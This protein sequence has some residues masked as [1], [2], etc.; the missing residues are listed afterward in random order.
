MGLLVDQ[1]PEPQSCTTASTT[2]G[3]LPSLPWAP[4]SEV[5]PAEG[6]EASPPRASRLSAQGWAPGGSS[7]VCRWTSPFLGCR[8]HTVSHDTWQ[9]FP[10]GKMVHYFYFK[11]LTSL[12]LVYQRGAAY[13]F[14][15]LEI[16]AEWK[17]SFWENIS[18]SWN[19]MFPPTH[20]QENTIGMY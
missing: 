5:L 15:F 14:N 17:M 20:F 10:G 4:P 12:S 9:V 7:A 18:I 8:S 19:H 13:I 11:P 16:T 6:W 1:V 3:L 2:W